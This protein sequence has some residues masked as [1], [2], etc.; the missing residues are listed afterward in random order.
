MHIFKATVLHD[1]QNNHCNDRLLSKALLSP[2]SISTVSIY[3]SPIINMV[4]PV[5]SSPKSLKLL[6]LCSDLIPSNLS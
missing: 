3:G 6:S 2:H 4:F 1:L 5:F